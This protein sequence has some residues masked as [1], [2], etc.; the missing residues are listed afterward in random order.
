[1]GAGVLGGRGRGGMAAMGAMV[2]CGAAMIVV[3]MDD[4]QQESLQ[5]LDVFLKRRFPSRWK[6]RSLALGRSSSMENVKL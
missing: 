1:M 6:G 3:M 2:L 5:P 4:L